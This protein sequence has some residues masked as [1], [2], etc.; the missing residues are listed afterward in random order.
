MRLWTSNMWWELLFMIL[1]PALIGLLIGIAG[2]V[3]VDPSA[4]Q[5]APTLNT[6]LTAKEIRTAVV[7]AINSN[8]S[9]VN[10][11]WP[12]VAMLFIGVAGLVVVR[13]L[14][15]QQTKDIKEHTENC[16]YS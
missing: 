11:L 8:A 15:A 3:G 1:I 10:D 2:C 5:G 7:T 12:V 4:S 16:T 6:A 9:I 13:V 14:N